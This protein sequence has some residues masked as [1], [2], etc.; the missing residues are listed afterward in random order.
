MVKQGY[1]TWNLLEGM[2][3]PL[4]LLTLLLPMYWGVFWEV[5]VEKREEEEKIYS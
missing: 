1:I 5:Q 3:P 4:H 2:P